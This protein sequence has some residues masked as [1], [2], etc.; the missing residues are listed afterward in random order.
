MGQIIDR[1]YHKKFAGSGKA[2]HL[3]AFAFL[4][5][6]DVFMETRLADI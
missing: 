4:G 5:R 1:G 6:D 2:V 3:A